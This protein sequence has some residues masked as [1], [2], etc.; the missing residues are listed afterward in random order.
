MQNNGPTYLEKILDFE[1][2]Y[3]NIPVEA[4]IELMKRLVFQFQNVISNAHF[5]IELLE[6]VLKNSLMMFDKEYFQQIFGII[7]G[8]NLAPILANLYLT[9]LQ[10]ELK[11]K[12]LHDSKQKW[13]KLFFRFIDDG[14]GIMEGTKKDVEYWINQFNGLRKTIKIDKWS[15]GN[16]VEYMDIYIYICLFCMLA[17]IGFFHSI[18]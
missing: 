18:V 1:S 16:H 14:F 2:L 10:E 9:M 12:C 4:A 8:T 17:G 5:V 3:T 11:K 15:F 7:M 6:T 13:P